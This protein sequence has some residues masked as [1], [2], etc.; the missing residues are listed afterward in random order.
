MTHQ[1]GTWESFE[2]PTALGSE[3]DR[4]RIHTT[5]APEP[6][7]RV[8]GRTVA[9]GMARDASVQIALGFAGVVLRAARSV[10]P[11]V[12]GRVEP[13]VGEAAARWYGAGH[14]DTPVAIDTVALQLVTTDA[15]R[16][17]L[18]RGL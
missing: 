3:A 15:A 16:V 11:D 7:G 2:G 1:A 18:A 17:V 13:A 5:S 10:G 6:S 14:A 9:L 12:W 4:V 8:T